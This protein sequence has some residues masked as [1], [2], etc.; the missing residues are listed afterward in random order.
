L[1][2]ISA[3]KGR[4]VALAGGA[5]QKVLPRRTPPRWR[6]RPGENPVWIRVEL[7]QALIALIRGGAQQAG[8]AVDA[9][10]STLLEF[11]ICAKAIETPGLAQELG[12]VVEEEPIRVAPVPAW[13]SWQKSLARQGAARAR[14]DELPELVVPERL[15]AACGGTLGVEQL[16]DAMARPWKMAVDLEL[17]AAGAG[18]TLSGYLPAR[19]LERA[20][21]V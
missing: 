7:N 21:R 6:C 8:V 14:E 1:R 18:Q 11:E 9:W 10:V 20:V 12:A 3:N 5:R 4:L 17:R 2:D 16:R 19:L 15:L 13:R